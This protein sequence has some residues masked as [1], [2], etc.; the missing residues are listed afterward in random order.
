M[1]EFE[2]RV[3]PKLRNRL[4]GKLILVTLL[5]A[6]AGSALAGDFASDLAKGNALT[7]E[8]YTADYDAYRAGLLETT[9]WP[10]WGLAMLCFFMLGLVL[11]AYEV[12]GAAFG[13]AVARLWAS[14]V[15]FF[16]FFMPSVLQ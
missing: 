1:S 4:V 7:L 12:L 10:T 13:W 2:F 5:S 15:F 9:Q 16:Y 3:S 8:L 6:L 11:V 14:L